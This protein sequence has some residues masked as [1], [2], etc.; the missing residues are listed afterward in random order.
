MKKLLLI[1]C[2]VLFIPYIVITL[3]VKTDETKFYYVSNDVIRVKDEKTGIINNVL[4]EEYI[5]GVLAGEMGPNFEKEALKAQAVAARSYAMY[6]MEKTKSDDYDVV[7]TVS[8]QVYLTDDD[9]KN[10]W[11]DKYNEKIKKIQNAVIE[12]KGEYMTYDGALVEALFFSTST[13]KTENSEEVF[14]SKVP[15]LRSVSSDWD[16]ISPVYT[17]TVTISLTDF[18]KKLDL[19][20]NE[21]LNINIT[22]RTSTGRVKTLKINDKEYT[23]R[24]VASKLSLRSNYFEIKKGDNNVIINTKGYGHGVGMS[25]YGAE[26]MA[27]KGYTYDKILKHY[28]TGI[29][30]HKK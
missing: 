15:Y 9:L 10:K 26:A 11:K 19:D 4:F 14:S 13:G 1:T 28:Y 20:Y 30:I 8:N 5:K 3:F 25:Q 17:D 6:K 2:L 29:E 12:T 16:S 23:G 7:N 18:Y 27:K 22:E 24:D 21:N